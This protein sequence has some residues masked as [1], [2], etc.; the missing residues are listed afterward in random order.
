MRNLVHTEATHETTPRNEKNGRNKEK[1]NRD[2]GRIGEKKWIM[3]KQ[4][5]FQ[6]KANKDLNNLE[7]RR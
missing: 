1:T 3:R 4:F 7:P 2:G 6:M 5:G